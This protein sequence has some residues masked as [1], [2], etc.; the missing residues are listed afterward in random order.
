MVALGWGGFPHWHG[1][2]IFFSL[3]FDLFRLR[4][5]VCACACAWDGMVLGWGLFLLAEYPDGVL[6]GYIHM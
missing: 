6:G 1:V 5:W 3:H 4:L 2:V